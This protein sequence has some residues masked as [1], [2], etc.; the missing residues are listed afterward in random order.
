MTSSCKVESEYIL[1]STDAEHDRLNRQGHLVSKITRHLLEEA[2][3]EPAMRVLD[4][5]SGV[6]DVAFLVAERVGP[7][8]HVS[9]LDTDRAAL[10]TARERA[11]AAGLTNISFHVGDLRRFQSSIGFDA[12]V[13]RCVLLHQSD[14]SAALESVVRQVNTG[15]LVI[16]QEPCFSLAFSN[17]PAPLFDQVIGWLHQTLSAG[18]F[19]MDVGMRLYSIFVSAGLPAPMLAFE[20]LVDG[21][22]ESDIYEYCTDTLRSLLPQMERLSITTAALVQV[23]TLAQRL[24][25]EAA[26]LGSLVGVMPL[27]GTW[28]RKP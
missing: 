22:P 11:A 4:V 23:E 21:N 7:T 3:V 10:Q 13:G 16:F 6:G 2:G 15:G 1:G 27:M 12:A 20:M 19:D 17:P 26:T 24:R 18:G 8:G 5:G 28:C 25:Q 14:P 9:C